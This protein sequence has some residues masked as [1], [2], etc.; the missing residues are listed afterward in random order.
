MTPMLQL[1]KVI[2][3]ALASGASGGVPRDL[4]DALASHPSSVED[5]VRLLFA[6][7]RKKRPNSQLIGAFGIMLEIA[8]EAARWRHENKSVAAID[9]AN[10]VR[11]AVLKEQCGDVAD[12]KALLVI[13]RSFSAARVDP[14][15]E[16]GRGIESSLQSGEDADRALPADDIERTFHHMAEELGHDCFLLHEQIRDLTQSA[17]VESRL[18]MMAILAASST[19]SLRDAVAGFAFDADPA[20]G[21]GIASILAQSAARGL[22]SSVTMGR[23]IIMRNWLAE[24]RR[25]ALDAVIRA[26]QVKGVPTTPR[27]SVQIA[28]ILVSPCDGAGAQSWFAVLR[29]RRKFSIA[30][31]LTKQGLGLR[32]AWV[33]TGLSTTEMRSFLAQIEV[34]MVCFSS[35]LDCVELALEH[36]LAAGA[37]KGEQIPFGVLHF[38]EATGIGALGARDHSPEALIALVLSAG[39]QNSVDE[40]AISGAL[41]RS[42][43][44]AKE[45]EWLDNWF[46]DSEAALAAVQRGTTKKD[47]IANVLRDVISPRRRYW[48]ELLAWTSLSVRDDPSY[49]DAEDFALVARELL[50][51]WPLIDIPVAVMIAKNT[52]EAMQTR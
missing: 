38:I 47:R 12:A 4:G 1:G 6:E 23:L 24:D 52:V 22:V 48:G 16:L 25:S 46:E 9:I 20:I 36:S 43:R 42:K 17:P 14:G 2:A 37:A 11:A 29:E 30:A 49:N 10:I 28:E 32:D 44:W 8:L 21:N 7:S 5:I 51:A 15:E 3:K 39:A 27:G 34:E 40:K 33:R 41:V 19:P 35:S 45:H 50:G 26:A 31:L 13:A 18:A